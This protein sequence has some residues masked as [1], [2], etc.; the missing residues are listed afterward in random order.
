MPTPEQ[1]GYMRAGLQGQGSP[2][3]TTHK[4][5]VDSPRS[6]RTPTSVRPH[7][8]GAGCPAGPVAV[9]GQPEGARTA[10][11][12]GLPDHRGLGADCSP[13]LRPVS[14][15]AVG[16][17][18]CRGGRDLPFPLPSPCEPQPSA[19][20]E[21]GGGGSSLIHPGWSLSSR[22]GTGRGGR[23]GGRRQTVWPSHRPPAKK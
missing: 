16:T 5:P 12:R 4:R 10:R 9:A 15:F 18:V 7:R 23:E 13:L 8:V 19:H 2:E 1:Q 21:T 3:G 20:L 6:V 11:V 22:L 17:G 14:I